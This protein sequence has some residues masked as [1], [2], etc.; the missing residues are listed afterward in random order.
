M[1]SRK[2]SSTLDCARLP[3]FIAFC[4]SSS[5]S[6]SSLRLPLAGIFARSGIGGARDDAAYRNKGDDKNS[7]FVPFNRL[8]LVFMNLFPS[9]FP[10]QLTIH[11]QKTFQTLPSPT[12]SHVFTY[13]LGLLL[14]Q[15]R[16]SA[17]LE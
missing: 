6:Q 14:L 10:F 7:P 15:D 17:R 2:S 16:Q 5:P 12:T 8:K 9:I 13:R 1:K 3:Q 4:L 11:Q